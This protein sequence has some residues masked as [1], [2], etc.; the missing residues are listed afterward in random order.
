MGT[1]LC[2]ILSSA[3]VTDICMYPIAL[4]MPFHI[5]HLFSCWIR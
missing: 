2:V 4:L 3:D 5:V 1:S